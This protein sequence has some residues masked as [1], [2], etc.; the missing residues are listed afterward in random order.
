[1]EQMAHRVLA[2]EEEGRGG[3][4]SLDLYDCGLSAR[5]AR[6]LPLLLEG[7]CGPALRQLVLDHN[8]LTAEA[9]RQGL[10]PALG[11]GR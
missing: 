10:A 5:H 7:C 1:M 11:E 8:L 3:L 4:A 9:V 2:G 6:G